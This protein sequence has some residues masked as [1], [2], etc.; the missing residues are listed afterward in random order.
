MNEEKWLSQM[1][2]RAREA[3]APRI[4]VTE[5]VLARIHESVP[6]SYDAMAIMAGSSMA[7]ACIVLIYAIQAWS[8]LNDPFSTML[9]SMSMVL[10]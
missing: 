1:A 7:A 5:A 2:A 6:E 8:A 3:S 4:D 9:A 10:Q